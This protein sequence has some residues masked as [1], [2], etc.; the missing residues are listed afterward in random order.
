MTNAPAFQPVSS[1][2]R[3]PWGAVIACTW[4]I[5]LTACVAPARVST[6]AK[7]DPGLAPPLMPEAASGRHLKSGRL[8]QKQ[9][10]AAAHPLAAQAG[11]E[12]L[13]QGGNALDAAIAAQAVL[14][15]VEPQSSG[16]GGGGLLML[17]DGRQVTAWDGRETAPAAADERLFLR[18]DGQVMGWQEAVVGGRSVGVPGLLS[19]LEQA[20]RRHGRLAWPR[21]FAP[22]VALAEQ[23]FPVGA[24]MHRLL[25]Q[26]QAL[27]QDAQARAYFY[28]PAGEPWPVGHSLRN[29][30]LAAVLRRIAQ[31]GASALMSGPVAADMVQ[32]VRGHARNPGLLAESDLAAYQPVQRQ[33][34]CTDWRTRWRICGF[35]PPAS[36]HLTLMQILGMMPP[37]TADTAMV[38][39]QAGPDWLHRYLERSRL[40]FA[41]RAQY[42]ADP[43][44]VAAPGGDWLSLLDPAYL[45]QRAALLGERSMGVAPA[46][47]PAAVR[48][49]MAPQ[50]E[51]PEYGTSHISV[52]DAQGHAVA[53]TSTIEAGFGARIMSDGGTGLAGGFLLNNELTDF[54]LRPRDAEGRPVA[55]RVEPGKRP[56]SSMSPSLV[57]DRR[58]GQFWMTLGA[59]GGAGIIHFVAKT[60]LAFEDWGMGL[61]EAI[62]LANFGNFNGTASVLEQ[63]LFPATTL[64]GLRARGHTVQEIELTSGLQGI[65][66]LDKAHAVNGQR[67]AHV[68]RWMGAA[69]PR[70]EGEVRGE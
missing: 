68:P 27:R 1:R 24:R 19:M 25:S 36:G 43:A 37:Q 18:P 41:D 33:A 32:R 8:L 56:R 63:G 30:A 66:R 29:P 17:W 28:G 10:V 57:F 51:Q 45:A 60:L 55:N 61:Q 42:I 38:D 26:E 6:P 52:V 59:P 64:A 2:I 46:G 31:E 3:R 44:F 47:Q 9:G 5:L 69:D 22:A 49:A 35:P 20:H 34:I 12:I 54:A 48:T 39:G 14:S 53:L 70:R 50:A 7:Q 13:Q 21:L 23:G 15:L 4:V 40:A 11:A 62:D 67:P 65:V 16:I 58:T